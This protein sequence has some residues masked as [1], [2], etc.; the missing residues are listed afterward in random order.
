MPNES[1]A[2][3][4]GPAGRHCRKAVVTL[5]RTRVAFSPHLQLKCQIFVLRKGMIS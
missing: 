5:L 1:A 2:L 4:C 3:V